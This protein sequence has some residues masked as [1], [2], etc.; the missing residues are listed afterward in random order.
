MNRLL[1]AA[2]ALAALCA[3]AVLRAAD[4]APA[5]PVIPGRVF[6]LP[7]YGAVGDGQ[8]VNTGAFR[9]A[10]DALAYAGGGTLV[11]PAG[12]WL[13]QPFDLGSNLN[14]HLDADAIIVFTANPD[15]SRTGPG[16]FRPF[17]QAREAHDVMISG[18]G[19][20]D[21]QG[22]AWW[23][24][25][26]RFRD[27]ANRTH[28]RSNTS[29]RPRLIVFDRCRRVRVEGVSLIR[30]PSFNLVP[31]RCED[32]SIVG[33]TILNPAD[34]PN[35]DGIDPSASRRVL[36]DHCRIDTGDDCI[37]VKAGTAGAIMEDLLITD[38]AF[39]HGHGCS[40]GSETFSGLRN[41]TVRRCTF[42][43]TDMGVRLKSDR[44]R[45]GLVENVTYTDLTMRHVGRPI[46]ISSYYQGTTTDLPAP[47]AHAEAQ[48]VTDTTPHWRNI[49]VRN[50]TATDST[51]DAGMILGLPEMPAENIALENVSI[52][53]PKGLRISY[54]RN[55]VLTN[56]RITAAAGEPLITDDTVANLSR[57]E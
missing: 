29:P 11:V 1:S 33:V 36:I 31:S 24:E 56:V 55:V 28:A 35:T 14:L 41:M 34:S 45:G 51:E 49:T 6:R 32:V 48:R 40:I 43:G 17:L 16:R 4:V 21:G 30:S 13:T 27:E 25:A 46:V 54:A 38:C 52:A 50:L 8:T 18:A 15:D 39:G 20:I 3:G 10:V 44:R 42:D 9:R 12:R 19:V 7:D 37:A 26:I 47:G 22:P 23:P 2:C 57:N 5:P 53:A